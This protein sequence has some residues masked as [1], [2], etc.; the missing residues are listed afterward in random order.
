MNKLCLVVSILMAGTLFTSAGAEEVKLF[1][2]AKAGDE[3]WVWGS[4]RAKR[5]D[6]KVLVS[7]HEKDAGAGDTYVATRFPYFPNGKVEFAV[8]KVLGGDYT[9]QVLGFRNNAHI[10]T[11][12]LV[13]HST[14]PAAKSFLLKDTGLTN[15]VD[16]ILLKIWVGGAK[17]A[18]V[19]VDELAYSFPLDGYDVLLDE[20][21]QN[22]ESWENESLVLRVTGEGA[23]LSLKTDT[24]FGSILLGKRFAKQ[25]GAKLLWNIV[26]VENG[27]ATLQFVGFDKD[28]KYVKSVDGVKNVRGGWYAVSFPMPGWPPEVESFQIKLWVGGEPTAAA[29]FGRLLIV[30]PSS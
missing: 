17:D 2:A 27:D 3:A 14:A 6:D 10:D 8:S 7:L 30:K 11:A 15:G 18:A 25:D 29:K 21:F 12:D 22:M 5:K 28:G 24:T 13:A 9:L 23:V 16:E 19:V 20:R 26:R 4:A 1:Q